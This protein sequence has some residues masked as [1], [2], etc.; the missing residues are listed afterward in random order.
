MNGDVLVGLLV[1]VVAGLLVGLLVGFARRSTDLAKLE[2]EHVKAL[3]DLQ[4]RCA[5]STAAEASRASSLQAELEAERRAAQERQAAW[6][7]ARR[8]MKGEL[9][10]LSAEALDANSK[11]F[12]ELA[13]T[14]M[15]QAQ[16]S[17][18]G[19]LMKRQQAIGELLDPLREQLGKYAES[20][21]QI[22]RARV[23][24]YEGIKEQVKQLTESQERLQAETRNLA[25]AL[26]APSTR[27]RWGEQQLRRVV[28]MAGMVEHCDFDDQVTTAGEEGR[29]RPDMVVHLPGAKQVVVDSKVPLQ[30]FLDAVDATDEAARKAHL[31]SH[32]R[33]LRAHVDSLAKKAYWRSFGDSL[34]FVVAFV[35]G[36]PLIAAAVGQDPSLY[37][38]AVA[39]HVLIATPTTLIALLHAVSYGWQ[40]EK[41]AEGAREV[42]QLGREI[43]GRLVTF[44]DHMAKVG[45]SLD[46]SVDAYNKAVGS[47]ERSVLPKARRFGDLGVVGEAERQIPELDPI[48]VTSRRLQ[49]PEL[50][51]SV[52][53]PLTGGA[54]DPE[55]EGA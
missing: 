28:E 2:A 3:A 51:S 19:D 22:E 7:E 30:A 52:E 8:Q 31:A 26:R 46:S 48:D 14:R 21:Q 47:L 33:Q 54:S 34:D 43:Y 36:D 25:S 42:Q 45:R 17:A 15:K 12:L 10:E 6:E 41:L 9:A 4:A 40:Q 11:R 29:A 38:Y 24:A 50:T 32:A 16:E 23:G 53:F 18:A 27:G 49:A 37:D 44:A 20:L 5:S 1:G 35:P 39:N 13:D 55:L